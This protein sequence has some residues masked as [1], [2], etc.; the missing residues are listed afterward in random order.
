MAIENSGTFSHHFIC[1]SSLLAE[2]MYFE[3]E[4]FLSLKK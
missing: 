3:L 2:T 4:E 1:S